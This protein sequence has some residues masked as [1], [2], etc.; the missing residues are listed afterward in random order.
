M[1]VNKG[2][3]K[4]ALKLVGLELVTS[5][6]EARVFTIRP[7]VLYG[8]DHVLSMC[9]VYI[10][11]LIRTAVSR[12]PVSHLSYCVTRWNKTGVPYFRGGRGVRP[13]S[14]DSNLCLYS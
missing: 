1:W 10:V 9:A 13:I 14:V 11:G 2:K 5:G 8:H 4:N 6:Q 12:H 3:E 7:P